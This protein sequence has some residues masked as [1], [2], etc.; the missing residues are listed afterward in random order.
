MLT[1][2]AKVIPRIVVL[3]APSK[4]TV[5]ETRVEPSSAPKIIT[6]ASAAVTAKPGITEFGA[7][8]IMSP[9]PKS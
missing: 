5:P 4:L 8:C 3:S 6:P 9:T 1:L 2:S 7:T